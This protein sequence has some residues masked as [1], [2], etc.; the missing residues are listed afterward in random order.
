[1]RSKIA[2][3]MSTTAFTAITSAATIAPQSS[4]ASQPGPFH[5]ATLIPD[6]SRY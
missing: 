3:R 6:E 4:A 1:M 5:K 2:G